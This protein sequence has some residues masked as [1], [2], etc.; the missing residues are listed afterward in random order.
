MPENLD[1]MEIISSAAQ[2]KINFFV[3]KFPLVK[4]FGPQKIF[5]L[6]KFLQQ[7]VFYG[8]FNR[9]EKNFCQT[10]SGNFSAW[11]KKFAPQN[12][13]LMGITGSVSINK[14][15]F[16]IKIETFYVLKNF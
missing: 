13:N 9:P 8:E 15:Q 16:F 14:N 1:L 12:L 11:F 5:K 10:K 3:K 2:I 4:N 7:I 6:T